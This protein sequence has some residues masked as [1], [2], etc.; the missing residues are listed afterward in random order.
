MHNMFDKIKRDSFIDELT[1]IAISEAFVARRLEPTIGRVAEKIFPRQRPISQLFNS[2]YSRIAG[3]KRTTF[4]SQL[5]GDTAGRANIRATP[6]TLQ[7]AR[8][9]AGH[10]QN[11]Q[12]AQA[13]R[14]VGNVG[15]NQASNYAAKPMQNAVAPAKTLIRSPMGFVPGKFNVAPAASSNA[16]GGLN[17]S[18]SPMKQPLSSMPAGGVQSKP[19]VVL[20]QQQQIK[21]AA[22]INELEKIA[23]KSEFKNLEKNKVPL[24]E[25]ERSEVMGRNAVWHHGPNGEKTPAVWKSINKNGKRTFITHTHRAYN[26]APT[27]KGAINRYHKFIKGTA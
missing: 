16:G 23:K 15:Y 2:N 12:P 25:N 18:P 27:L 21:Y 5:I 4:A 13:E 7:N 24:T 20:P 6:Q 17:F 11:M 8:Q 14:I 1:K 26:T 22:F 19:G 9:M 3:D 10:I